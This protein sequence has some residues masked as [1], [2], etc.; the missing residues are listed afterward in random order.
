M[1]ARK[2]LRYTKTKASAATLLRHYLRWRE[3]QTPPLPTRCD[4]PEC[5]F[6]TNPLVWNGKPLVPI[7]DHENGVNSDNRPE[8]LRLLCPNCD[9]QLHTRGG[10]NKGRIEKAEGGFAIRRRGGLRDYV[11]PAESDIVRIGS[12]DAR[13]TAAQNP[14]AAEDDRTGD[15]PA[16][17]TWRHSVAGDRRPA[18]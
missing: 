16:G 1:N 12:E 2:I 13:L 8:N 18:V 15:A 10:A 11:L 4:N 5:H 3:Q 6:H 9:S 7:L 17:W 14:P